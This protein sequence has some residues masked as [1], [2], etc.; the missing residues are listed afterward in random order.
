MPIIPS[1]S[2]DWKI[3]N[4]LYLHGS[5]LFV[6]NAGNS[7]DVTL[8]FEDAHIIPPFSREET[9]NTDDTDDTDDIDDIYDTDGTDDTDDK[10]DTDDTNDTYVTEDFMRT[11]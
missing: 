3:W 10:D 1:P 5:G 2:I 11:F 9:K 8:A 7:S 4:A 6:C